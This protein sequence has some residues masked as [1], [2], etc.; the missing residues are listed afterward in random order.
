M[1]LPLHAGVKTIIRQVREKEKR[2]IQGQARDQERL[3]NCALDEKSEKHGAEVERLRDRVLQ[4]ER[5]LHAALESSCSTE[6]MT[7]SVYVCFSAEE[8]S[9]WLRVC[10]SGLGG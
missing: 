6:S 4:L 1:H 5:Y 8:S 7:V 9:W 2:V 3:V 10:G